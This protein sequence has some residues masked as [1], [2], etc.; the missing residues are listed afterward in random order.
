MNLISLKSRSSQQRLS[1]ILIITFV[2]LYQ[3]AKY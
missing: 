2:D 1:R 3:L